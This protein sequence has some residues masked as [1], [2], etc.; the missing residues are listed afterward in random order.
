MAVYLLDRGTEVK[1][2]GYFLAFLMFF[3]FQLPAEMHGG[4]GS[5]SVSPPKADLGDGR[6]FLFGIT[7]EFDE[8][9]SGVGFR[10]YVKR[11]QK[12][13]PKATIIEVRPFTKERLAE[14]YRTIEKNEYRQVDAYLFTHGTFENEKFKFQMDDKKGDPVEIE[15]AEMEIPAHRANYYLLTCHAGGAHESRCLPSAKAIFVASPSHKA[16]SPVQI[17]GDSLFTIA[18]SSDR[19]PQNPLEFWRRTES[20]YMDAYLK[21]AKDSP[22]AA[23]PRPS[24]CVF[25]GKIYGGVCEKT[26]KKY[27]KQRRDEAA[28]SSGRATVR[29]I[30]D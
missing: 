15:G 7:N 23:L 27:E 3:S 12:D 22:F 21:T 19:L 4:E 11:V 14:I 30:G 29:I 8:L 26:Y 2:I 13:Y 18:K 9:T 5:K 28:K 10:E 25:D 24:G 16:S 6:L 20:L 1:T 17:I